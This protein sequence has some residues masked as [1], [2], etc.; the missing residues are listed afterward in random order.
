MKEE[1]LS[2]NFPVALRPNAGQE[3]LII[4]VPSTHTTKYHSRYYSTGR[5]ISSSQRPLPDNINTHNRHISMYSAIKKVIH[6]CKIL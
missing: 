5:V 4:E 1:N 6:W 2:F 3:I